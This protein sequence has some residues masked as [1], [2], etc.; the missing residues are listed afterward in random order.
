MRCHRRCATDH[1]HSSGEW[2]YVA[3]RDSGSIS[4][5][6][7]EGKL[8]GETKVAEQLSDFVPVPKTDLFLATDEKKHELLVLRI[9]KDQVSIVQRVSVSQYPVGVTVWNEC[10]TVAVTSLWSQRLTFVDLNVKEVSNKTP[11][12][13]TK[14]IDL[15]FAPRKLLMLP[16]EQRLIVAD[17]F[18][19]RL[20][21]VDPV[22]YEIEV[23]RQFPG[24][25]IRGL[26]L[27]EPVSALECSPC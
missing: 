8:R 4:V 25:N 9:V 3:N 10:Q 21:V 24:H 19:G 12:R 7:A 15:P 6:T 1:R 2:L 13:I 27:R 11:A 17:S 26:A 20:A 22:K 23:V 16:G 18:S 14:V 5:L